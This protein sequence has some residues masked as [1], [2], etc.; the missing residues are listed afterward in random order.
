MGVLKRG[1]IRRTSPITSG[2]GG[3]ARARAVKIGLTDEIDRG[4]A[5]SS[6]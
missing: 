6:N 2:E 4:E 3:P 5:D 1:M